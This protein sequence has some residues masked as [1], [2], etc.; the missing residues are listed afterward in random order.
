MTRILL[1]KVKL[2]NDEFRSLKNEIIMN[3]SKSGKISIDE[4]KIKELSESIKYNDSD[5]M[6]D[7][8]FKLLDKIVFSK[9]KKYKNK[10]YLREAELSAYFA[11][12][13]NSI[14]KSIM[15]DADL[16]TYLNTTVLLKYVKQMYLKGND[17]NPE[18]RIERYLFNTS[19]HSKIDRTGMRFLWLFGSKLEL[20]KDIERANT[21][22]EFID[23]VKAIFERKLSCNDYIV[24][25]FVDAITK[26][27]RNNILKNDQMK[28]VVPKHIQ[29]FA[30]V[31]N[32][33]AFE[34]EE[35]VDIMQKEQ[36][37]M[38]E[39]YT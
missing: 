5:L 11:R 24:R 22:M 33:D 2:K 34:Y 9:N 1:K 28:K 21:A 4:G 30:G 27:G 37:R 29:C 25:A 13:F 38:I 19:S 36:D 26:G 3:Y 12:I 18:D 35:L 32:L 16:W 6:V 23:P 15:Y 17:K 8:D 10:K 14:P 20:D 39:L 7:I 31:T